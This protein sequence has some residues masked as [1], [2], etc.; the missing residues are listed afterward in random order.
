[1]LLTFSLNVFDFQYRKAKMIIKQIIIPN[2]LP[3]TIQ[4]LFSYSSRSP[5]VDFTAL[6][7]VSRCSSITCSSSDFLTVTFLSTLVIATCNNISDPKFM[8]LPSNE[9][10]FG[11]PLSRTFRPWSSVTDSKQPVGSCMTPALESF[12]ISLIRLPSL[13]NV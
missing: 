4:N 6:E 7:T 1:M 11:W 9:T 10:Y 13:Q 5:L 8:S 2:K 3:V 12:L